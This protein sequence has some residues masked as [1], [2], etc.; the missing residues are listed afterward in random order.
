MAKWLLVL[1]G[2]AAVTW[3]ASRPSS[4]SSKRVKQGDNIKVKECPHCGVYVEEGI[5]C[6]CGKKAE[7]AEGAEK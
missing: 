2:V 7:G 4:R 3:W 6:R 1:I 5:P